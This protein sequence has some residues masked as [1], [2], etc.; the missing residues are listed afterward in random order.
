MVKGCHGLQYC[1]PPNQLDAARLWKRCWDEL[2]PSTV[3][4]CWEQA[5]C[6]PRPS[7]AGTVLAEN[8]DLSKSVLK[9]VCAQLSSTEAILKQWIQSE[10][11]PEVVAYATMD[12]F[13][14]LSAKLDVTA[15][16]SRQLQERPPGTTGMGG[17]C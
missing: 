4:S 16:A 13:D 15:T 5:C 9:K 6:L 10:E 11:D 3:V 1:L 12:K 2:E 7:A 8:L 17:R 14:K